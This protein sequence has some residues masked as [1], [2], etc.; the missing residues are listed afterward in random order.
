MKFG[1][2][3]NELMDAQKVLQ[4]LGFYDNAVDGLYGSGSQRAITMYQ[5]K[6]NLPTS[7]LLDVSTKQALYCEKI[8][9]EIASEDDLFD[10]ESILNAIKKKGYILRYRQYEINLIGVRIGGYDNKFTDKLFVIWKNEKMQ[11]EKRDF[12]WTTVAGTE[13]QGF[14]NPI[15]VMGITGT[16]VLK[17]GQYLRKWTLVDSYSGWLNYPYFYQSGKVTI[18][19]D[20]NKDNDL[21]YDAPQQSDLFGINLHRMSN[22]SIDSNT[23]NS[24]WASWSIGCQGTPEPT[25]AQIVELARITSSLY[26]NEFDYTLLNKTDFEA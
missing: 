4:L 11:W 15:T 13:G 7:G 18:Y 22:N 5:Y 20:G 9:S 8:A 24:A 17:E 3:S 14:N 26:G 12:K 1:D 19:R 10:I 16:A 23:V 25:F 2:F 21:E 6:K